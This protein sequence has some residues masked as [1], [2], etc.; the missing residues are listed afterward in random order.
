[1]KR[2]L[3]FGLVSVITAFEIGVTHGKECQDVNLPE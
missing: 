2:S 3:L 1:M